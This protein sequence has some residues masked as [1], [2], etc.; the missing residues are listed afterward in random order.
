MTISATSHWATSFPCTDHGDWNVMQGHA[1]YCEAYGHA[2]LEVDGVYQDHCPR[3]GKI[4]KFAPKG[5]PEPEPK[6][7]PEG[8][9]MI[10]DFT[11]C[12]CNKKFTGLEHGAVIRRMSKHFEE[13]AK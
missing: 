12:T 3:C 1:D 7:E 6:L 5:E 11:W 9:E 8:T 13:A 4:G 10:H 2:F